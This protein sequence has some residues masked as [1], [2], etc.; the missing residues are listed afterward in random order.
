MALWLSLMFC[1]IRSCRFAHGFLLPDDG[2]LPCQ[3]GKLLNVGLEAGASCPGSFAVLARVLTL[4][5]NVPVPEGSAFW[6]NP[7]NAMP[8]HHQYDDH[9]T[10]HVTC[11]AVWADQVLD[12]QQMGQLKR[13]SQSNAL[14][15]WGTP[16]KAQGGQ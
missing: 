16:P 12:H 10:C 11:V 7:P 6:C 5:N 3:E 2:M 14:R 13:P 1:L 9:V 4:G 8:S 15:G